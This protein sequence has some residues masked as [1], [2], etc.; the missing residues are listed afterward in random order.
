[1]GA[2]QQLTEQLNKLRGTRTLIVGIGQLLKGDDG[3]GPLI[4]QQL[5]GKTSADLIDAGTVPE[6]YI[7]PI[8][9]K[10]PQNLLVIDAI[11]FGAPAGTIRIF[12]PEQLN[13]LVLSTHTL[14][15]RL[16]VDMVCE[17]IDVDVYFVGIQP[18]QL[19]LGQ[20]VSAEVDR[21]IQI[22]S[23]TLAE[24]FPLGNS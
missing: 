24:T 3:A 13:S 18:A 9:K 22:L 16:F 20:S 5:A 14:S 2:D 12:K 19:G 21:A 1:M 15:P 6:N 4:C 11:D 10:A 7:Q 17:N 23:D 8:I